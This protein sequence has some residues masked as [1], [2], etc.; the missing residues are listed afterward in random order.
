MREQLYLYYYTCKY[1]CKHNN[2]IVKNVLP[3]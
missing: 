1:V 3:A 2:V